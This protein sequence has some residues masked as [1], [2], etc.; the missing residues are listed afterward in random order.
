MKR[1]DSCESHE[2]H[3]GVVC[4]CKRKGEREHCKKMMKMQLWTE[5]RGTPDQWHVSLVWAEDGPW[6][7]SL[8]WAEDGPFA[9]LPQ[10]GAEKSSA[11]NHI[12]VY[13][14]WWW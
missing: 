12:A 5:A 10:K 1:A 4:V 9:L 8:V 2:L 13:K 14:W 11:H 3:L 6:H 7:V